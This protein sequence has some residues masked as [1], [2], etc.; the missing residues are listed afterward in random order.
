MKFSIILNN[1][2][3]HVY[4]KTNFKFSNLKI[5]LINCYKIKNFN[6]NNNCNNYNKNMN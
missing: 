2:V 5:K 6:N 1:W 3:N 4:F